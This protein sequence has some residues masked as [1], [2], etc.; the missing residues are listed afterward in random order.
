MLHAAADLQ[1]RTGEF[2][3]KGAEVALVAGLVVL[4][5][6]ATGVIKTG[7]V[8]IQMPWNRNER[9]EE[10][11]EFNIVIAFCGSTCNGKL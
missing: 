1:A 4:G 7:S 6:W 11:R 8:M 10:K 3:E 5:L 9:S 2:S